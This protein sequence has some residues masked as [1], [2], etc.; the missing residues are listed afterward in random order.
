MKRQFSTG[1]FYGQLDGHWVTSEIKLL[2]FGLVLGRLDEWSGRNFG[3][4]CLA[5]LRLEM[6]IASILP[7]DTVTAKYR[8][9]L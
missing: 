9:Q 6:Q 1:D 8:E 4:A 2:R 7:F 3:S 5:R